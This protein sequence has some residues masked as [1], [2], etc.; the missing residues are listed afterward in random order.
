VT[1]LYGPPD[2][3][4]GPESWPFAPIEELDCYLET[5][6]EPSLVQLETHVQ[7]HLDPAALASA[8]A[9]ALAADPAARRHLVATSRWRRRLRW[10]APVPGGR[11]GAALTVIS[12]E[13][14]EDLTALRDRLSAWPIPLRYG[15]VRLI[16]G[17]GPE[18]DVVVLQTHHA[19]FDGISSVTLLTAICAAYRDARVTGGSRQQ[20]GGGP[21]AVIP[22]AGF[23]QPARPGRPRVSRV[24]GPVTRIAPQ[25]RLLGRS[26]Y[27]SVRRQVPVPRP[28]RRGTG[29]FPTVNDLLVTA[30]ILTVERW[31]AAHGRRSGLIRIGIPVND[32]D[33]RHRWDGSGN[34]TRLIRVTT[35]PGQRTDAAALLAHV[36]AQTRAAR[37]QPR[38]G[39]DAASRL[40]GTGW[41]PI[42]VKGRTARLVQ[43]LAAPVGT[44]TSV[45]SNLGVIPDPP[46][47]SGGG[48]EPLWF[49][50]PARMP[51]GLGM[52]AAT[53]GGRLYLCVHYQHALLG[54]Q[55]AER[56][57]A[58]CCQA[59]DEL[60]GLPQGRQA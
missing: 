34:Q 10:A 4:A 22:P 41:A 55:A 60:A 11:A 43:R 45:V 40:L 1:T 44:D 52:G 23:G 29:P 20:A 56:F 48:Q 49:S 27:G 54:P 6:A 25:D 53:V 18:H 15:A 36:A 57:T 58:M 21:P 51:R 46:S 33:P 5:A 9:D 13:T 59:L 16:L 37:R 17:P 35:R 3:Q 47:F 14:P 50:G 24:P 8:L 30:L 39:L 26:G 38:P 28:A 32:R 42:A 12:W 2:V 19:A 7:G 31:N